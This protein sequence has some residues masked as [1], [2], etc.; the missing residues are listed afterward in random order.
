METYTA[1]TTLSR[2]APP[3]DALTDEVLTILWD[4]GGTLTA[5]EWQRLQIMCT[6]EADSMDNAMTTACSLFSRWPDQV[7][8]EILNEAEFVAWAHPQDYAT[9]TQAAT[10]LGVSRQSILQRIQR[11]TLPARRRG[12]RWAVPWSALNVATARG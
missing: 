1:I 9:V 10:E 6:I 8:V 11:G 3:D 7:K 12:R 2:T 5:D 4:V